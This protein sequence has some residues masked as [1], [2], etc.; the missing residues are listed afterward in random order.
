MATKTRIYLWFERI[1][2]AQVVGSSPTTGF[3]TVF[4][5]E[6]TVF[7]YHITKTQYRNEGLYGTFYLDTSTSTA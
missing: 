2:N 6:K 4:S 7:S 3:K 5:L 1:R